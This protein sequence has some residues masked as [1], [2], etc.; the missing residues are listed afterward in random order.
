MAFIY[1]STKNLV[2]SIVDDDYSILTRG[3]I[4]DFFGRNSP[5]D[6]RN[7]IY[8][9]Y[10]GLVKF[11]GVSIE[12]LNNCF[13]TNRL[14]ELIYAKNSHAKS[15]YYQQFVVNKI[16]IGKTCYSASELSDEPDESDDIVSPMPIYNM[17]HCPSCN[18]SG[19]ITEKHRKINGPPDCV[20]CY[21]LICTKCSLQR[22]KENGHMCKTCIKRFDTIT[23]MISAFQ[24]SEKPSLKFTNCKKGDYKAIIS[25]C[26]DRK[27]YSTELLIDDGMCIT[28]S[29]SKKI[30]FNRMISGEDNY[31]DEISKLVRAKKIFINQKAYPT[32]VMH[33]QQDTKI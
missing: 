11:Q 26:K 18:T 23:S 14:D 1:P 16:Q 7:I 28:W 27:S 29:R 9:V 25:G 2:K 13:A 22:D 5:D 20:S 8:C 33:K 30:L 6:N 31:N 17:D 32:H 3:T 15:H 24:T 21:K 4:A 12:L 10:A 19:Y